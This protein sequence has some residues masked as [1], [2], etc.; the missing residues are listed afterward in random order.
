MCRRV[1][2]PP[3]PS[4]EALFAACGSCAAVPAIPVEII[5]AVLSFIHPI[6]VW[7]LRQVSKCFNYCITRKHFLLSNLRRF[8]PAD[9]THRV[10]T[11]APTEWD[12][13]MMRAPDSLQ[14]IFCNLLFSKTEC[15]LWSLPIESSCWRPHPPA[16]FATI[17]RSIG[18]MRSLV[19]LEMEG[20]GLMGTIPEEIY[21]LTELISLS[22]AGNQLEGEI[23]TQIGRLV[24]LK[25]LNFERN[26]LSGAIP[27]ELCS[28]INLEELT[29]SSNKLS[30]SIPTE[31]GNLP[32]L[33][34]LSLAENSLTG[35][36]PSII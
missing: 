22:F 12:E 2:S 1:P 10:E 14:S 4:S 20:C 25:A 36:I 34:Y 11:V 32:N 35:E 7:K 19:K 9:L 33:K 17:P 30:G 29:F 15:V 8:V 5:S 26:M 16:S 13:L 24:N 28:C 3:S 27:A 21:S 6:T 23:S 18:S 31:L